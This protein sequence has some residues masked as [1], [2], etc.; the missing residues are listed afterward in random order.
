MEES[1][2]RRVAILGAG[3]VGVEAALS[4]REQ[5]FDVKLFERGEVGEHVKHWGHVQ[6]FSP[7][8]LNRSERGERLLQEMGQELEPEDAFPLGS[9]YV[10]RYLEPLSKHPLLENCVYTHHE[11]ISVARAQVLKG[12][13]IGDS[14]RADV[15]FLMVVEDAQGVQSYHEADVVIDTTG[16]Y[17]K[18]AALGPGGVGAIGERD[19]E[20][21]R[22]VPDMEDDSSFDYRGKRVLVVGAGYSAVTTLK[23]LRELNEAHPEAPAKV[24]WSWREGAAPY[25]E[26]EGDVL[27][28]RAALARFGNEVSRGEV[29]G[30]EPCPMTQVWM[31]SREPGQDSTKVFLKDLKTHLI[32]EV[33]VDRVIANVGYLPDTELYR[34]LQVHLC[35]ASE[36]PMKL[37][38][39]L[40]AA[41]GGGGDCL[42][43]TSAGVETLLNPEPNF[44]ILGAKSYGRGSAF[45][46]RLGLEQIE[47]VMTLLS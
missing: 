40:L 23:L 24:F 17:G 7:W 19:C 28:Q 15:P 43:Q 39:S 31:F 1:K 29:E 2:R 8:S 9:E 46:I 30:I 45:L 6:L 11:V 37:A 38:A 4:A 12:E 41:S 36:G 5:G 21:E 20:V 25:M 27:P 44:F 3:P 33:V 18:P 16:S 32:E 13:L 26:I 22:Y 14:A 10:A 35:Y 47:Q 34:E 42:A